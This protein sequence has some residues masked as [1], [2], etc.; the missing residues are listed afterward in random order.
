MKENQMEPLEFIK[1]GE[2]LLAIILRREYTKE[3]TEFFT[4]EDFP[5]QVG[6]ISKKKGEIIGAHIHR[7]VKREISLTQE[8]L[9]VRKG[10]IRADFYDSEKAYVDSR[11]LKQGDVIL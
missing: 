4:P 8:V 5:Q 10:E 2:D 9:F 11:V 6:F 3:G 7:L 1:K